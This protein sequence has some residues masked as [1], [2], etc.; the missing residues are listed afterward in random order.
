[1]SPAML[2]GFWPLVGSLLLFAALAT[3]AICLGPDEIP[4]DQP[5]EGEEQP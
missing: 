1:M 3:L 4:Y 5:E 2:D